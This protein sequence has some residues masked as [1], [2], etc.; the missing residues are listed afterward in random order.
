MNQRQS[1]VSKRQQ[2]DNHYGV[3]NN[4]ISRIVFHVC[5]VI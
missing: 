4:E 1:T 5:A 2:Q 3:P